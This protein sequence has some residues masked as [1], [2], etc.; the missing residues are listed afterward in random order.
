MLVEGS[1]PTPAGLADGLGPE[2]LPYAIKRLAPIKRVPRSRLRRDSAIEWRE[3]TPLDW[4]IQ[5]A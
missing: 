4:G 1:C 3:D 5:V 2:R